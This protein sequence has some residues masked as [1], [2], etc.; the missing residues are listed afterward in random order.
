MLKE[1]AAEYISFADFV[2]QTQREIE[3]ADMG[4]EGIGAD[5]KTYT[6]NYESET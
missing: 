1:K 2:A 5:E 4:G 3:L 6:Y